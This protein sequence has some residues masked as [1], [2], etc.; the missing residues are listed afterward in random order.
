MHPVWYE[1]PKKPKRK[2]YPKRRGQIERF[3]STATW[4]K[5]REEVLTRDH[6][7]CRVCLDADHR[8]NNRG[9][10]VH[11]ITP[12]GKDFERR[13]DIDNLIT[14]CSKHHDE[15][16]HGLIPANRLRELAKTSPRL[17]N[18]QEEADP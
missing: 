11:H 16:E 9:L 6:Y 15:A 12:L 7:L 5:K 3:R 14:L 4:Q 18:L 8:I 13:L 1:C 2:W 10:S 17:P